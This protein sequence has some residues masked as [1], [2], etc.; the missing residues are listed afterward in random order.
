[1]LVD[2]PLV[3]STMSNRGVGKTGEPVAALLL[4]RADHV[5]PIH[6]RLFAE[7][8]H[9]VDRGKALSDVDSGALRFVL[10]P[11][12]ARHPQRALNLRQQ[13]AGQARLG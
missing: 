5:G 13:H 2:D 6:R 9:G 7:L 3:V 11:R 8:Q 4:L 12:L 1:M 10:S